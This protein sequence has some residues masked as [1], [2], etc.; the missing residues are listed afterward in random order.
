M[1]KCNYTL[2]GNFIFQDFEGK[3]SKY[4]MFIFTQVQE[5]ILCLMMTKNKYQNY[6]I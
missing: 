2:S 3:A 5:N 1:R 6:V 4:F